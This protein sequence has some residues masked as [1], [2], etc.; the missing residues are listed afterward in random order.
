MHTGGQYN[1]EATKWTKELAAF[2]QS[3]GV[4]FVIG[5][6][7]HVIHGGDFSHLREGRFA[8]YCL[9]DLSSCTGL[10]TDIPDGGT[11]RLVVFTIALHLDLERGANGAARLAGVSFGVLVRRKGASVGRL[12]VHLAAEPWRAMPS[13]VERDAFAR[14][15]REAAGIFAGRSFA[16]APIADEYAL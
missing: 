9:G 6:H 2:T 1:P 12:S 11:P 14:D 8:A 15:I 13:G 3:C 16:D 7:E 5:N 4:D 10:W